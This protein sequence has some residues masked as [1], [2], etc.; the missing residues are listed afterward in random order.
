MQLSQTLV[1]NAVPSADSYIAALFAT[2]GSLIQEFPVVVPE[3]ELSVLCAGQPTGNYQAKVKSV[4]T[5][6]ESDYST[7]LAFSLDAPP[8]PEN[9]HIV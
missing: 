5:V 7:P 6:G 9:L 1:W 4:N 8:A 3:I 2:T